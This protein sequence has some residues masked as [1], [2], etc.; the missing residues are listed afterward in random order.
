MSISLITQTVTTCFKAKLT[1]C[2]P[3][4]YIFQRTHQRSRLSVLSKLCYAIGGAPYQITGS[5]LGFFLQIYLLEV[6]QVINQSY[7]HVTQ[8]TH[9]GPSF[10]RARKHDV[11]CSFDSLTKKIFC[12]S[13]KLL[14]QSLSVNSAR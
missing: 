11:L 3:L 13:R 10:F 12:I 6:A 9:L 7:T 14:F 5:A 8:K 4:T 1:A 2:P